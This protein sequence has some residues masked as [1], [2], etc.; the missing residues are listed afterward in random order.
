MVITSI[1]KEIST[2]SD[3]HLQSWKLAVVISSL[4]LGTFLV[5]LDMNIIGVAVPKIT[6]E[7]DSLEDIAWYGE[8]YP[9][10][11]TAFQPFFG[12]LYKFFNTKVVYMSS[13]VLFE[14]G[15]PSWSHYCPC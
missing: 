9:L 2:A 6:S 7:F 1:K 4:C 5:A 14:G 13:I 11:V 8:V 15:K 3:A 10:T 12:N